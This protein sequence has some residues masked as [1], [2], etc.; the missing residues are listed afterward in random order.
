MG[1]CWVRAGNEVSGTPA[2]SASKTVIWNT[3]V[4]AGVVEQSKLQ[5]S[6][7]ASGTANLS[8]DCVPVPLSSK[9]G[10]GSVV[11]TGT[12]VEDDEDEEDEDGGDARP[13]S[14]HA[15]APNAATSTDT[16]TVTA[17]PRRVGGLR[18]HP[19]RRPRGGVEA[20]GI[21]VGSV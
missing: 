18:A 20:D 15:A 3:P 7:H 8:V 13:V 12:L 17:A 10:G 21:S 4:I 14:R 16:T 2:L 5:A 9:S 1:P 11:A 6:V 19:T